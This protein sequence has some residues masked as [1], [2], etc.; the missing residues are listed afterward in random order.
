MIHTFINVCTRCIPG[1][2]LDSPIEHNHI[3]ESVL[4]EVIRSGETK[5]ARSDDT[6]DLGRR[7]VKMCGLG[8]NFRYRARLGII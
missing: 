2:Q 1:R 7:G 6:K 3:S 5:R 8:P 4:L